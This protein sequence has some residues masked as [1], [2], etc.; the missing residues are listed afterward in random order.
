MKNIQRSYIKY[1]VGLTL[2]LIVLVG[3]FVFPTVKIHY[4][5]QHQQLYV[6][7]TTKRLYARSVQDSDRSHFEQL[8]GDPA[9]NGPLSYDTISPRDTE[10]ILKD[11]WINKWKRHIPFS[12]FAVFD[13]KTRTFMGFMRIERTSNVPGQLEIAYALK[14]DYWGKG[15]G[16]EMIQALVHR[17]IPYLINM[18]ITVRGTP[19]T[20]IVANCRADNI[21]SQRVLEKNQFTFTEQILTKKYYSYKIVQ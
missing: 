19:I 3:Y 14:T 7:I 13:K 2:A 15:Y 9:V 5:D 20:E 1:C 11:R 4:D 12:G 8:F 17:Y 21:G 6:E 18:G 16:T 10:G